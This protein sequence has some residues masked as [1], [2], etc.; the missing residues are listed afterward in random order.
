MHAGVAV[1]REPIMLA[2]FGKHL[3]GPVVEDW[4]TCLGA[5]RAN[6]TVGDEFQD[7]RGT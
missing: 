7:V 4:V 6:F 2:S 1:D 5:A 3:G